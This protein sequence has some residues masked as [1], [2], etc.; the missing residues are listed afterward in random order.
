[1]QRLTTIGRFLREYARRKAM[2]NWKT[3]VLKS[4]FTDDRVLQKS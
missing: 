1:M 2:R 3:Q 4:G